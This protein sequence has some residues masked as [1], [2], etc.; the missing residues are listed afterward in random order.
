[1]CAGGAIA[2]ALTGDAYNMYHDWKLNDVN[3]VLKKFAEHVKA[4]TEDDDLNLEWP[5]ERVA[6]WNDRLGAEGEATVLKALMELH[7]IEVQNG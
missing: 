2:K 7:E 4:P 1:M 5:S 3:A 6:T